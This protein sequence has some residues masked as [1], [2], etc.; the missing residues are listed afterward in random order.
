MKTKP[1]FTKEKTLPNQK[2]DCQKCKLHLNCVSPYMKETGRG[3]KKILIVGE[4]PG[5][6]TTEQLLKKTLEENNIN[7]KIDCWVT[8]VVGCLP[9]KDRT[10]TDREI[11]C[12]LPRLKKLIEDKNPK[13]IILLG[14]VAVKSFLLGKMKGAPGGINRWR[15]FIIPDQKNGVW[16]AP[17]FHPNYILEKE[18]SSYKTEN[19]IVQKIFNL[20]IKKALKKLNQKVPKYSYKINMSKDEKQILD[21][22]KKQIECPPEML[23]FDYETTGLKPYEKGH[24]IAYV[25]F[26]FSD[27]ESFV[28]EPT[29]KIIRYWKKILNSR[30]I[31]KT[32]HNIKFEHQWSK[33]IWGVDVRGWKHDSM[34][35]AH[36][37]DNR[38][39]IT[40]LDFQAYTM[41]GQEDY[42]SHLKKFLEADESGFNKVFEAPKE[43]M[44]EYCGMDA[45]LQFRLAK[46][47][48]H[49]SNFSVTQENDVVLFTWSSIPDVDF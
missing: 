21:I 1:F 7:L 11:K 35:A 22:L 42:S 18:Y 19:P 15:G 41:F 39:R 16:I 3:R 29:D 40:S 49:G 27:K 8:N 38:A 24:R 28:F 23:A 45:L 44:M 26:C 32:A 12:C 20:D 34:V 31:K 33:N 14:G 17:V 36:I 4:A 43:E 5:K 47:Q 2:T 25:G 46:I 6:K 9:P 30:R 48:H 10:P 37:M 13:L